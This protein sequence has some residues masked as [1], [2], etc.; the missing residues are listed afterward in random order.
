MTL[1]EGVEP[2][3]VV[4]GRVAGL[5]AGTAVVELGGGAQLVVARGRLEVGQLAVV[6][7][8]SDDVLVALCRSDWVARAHARVFAVCAQILNEATSCGRG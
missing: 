2:D 3:N 8:R 1:A 7:V 4:R 5:G 6:A